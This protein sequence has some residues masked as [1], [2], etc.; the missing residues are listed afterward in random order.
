M[1]ARWLI[2]IQVCCVL[3]AA[4]LIWPVNSYEGSRY[5]EYVN[6]DYLYSVR[7][8]AELIGLEGTAPAARQGFTVQLSS[9]DPGYIR[10][11]ADSSV[12]ELSAARPDYSQSSLRG[13]ERLKTNMEKT[14]L[15]KL[16][17]VRIRQWLRRRSDR[18]MFIS[19]EITAIRW[20]Q[21]IHYS[22]N[23]QTPERHYNKRVRVF[24]ALVASFRLL[25]T[26]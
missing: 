18:A 19:D 11:A 21:R 25:P 17:A 16:A 23:L 15:H 26:P 13:F 8:P 12:F 20:D 6:V 4:Q 9:D 14:R 5:T 3:L 22:L 24:D 7:I 2:R 1:K 10:A